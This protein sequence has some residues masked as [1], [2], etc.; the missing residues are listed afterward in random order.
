MTK[1]HNPTSGIKGVWITAKNAL[2]GGSTVWV[3]PGETVE[4]DGMTESEISAF[5]ASGGVVSDETVKRG[6]GRPPKSDA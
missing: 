5:R 1:L 6:P 2:F 4:I 3:N